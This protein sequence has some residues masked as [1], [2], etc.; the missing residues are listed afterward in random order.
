MDVKGFDKEKIIRYWIDSA[1]EDYGTMLTL[2]ENNKNSWALFVGHLV[3]EKLLKGLYVKVNED[4]PPL[5]HNLLRLAELC[6]L[7]LNQEE[8]LFYATVTTFNINA[9]YDDYKTNFRKKCT[10]EYTKQWVNEIKD[11]KE[12]IQK[13]IT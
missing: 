3:I 1:E 12:W 8:K 4:Y 7:E 9:R 13:Q 2:Y 10:P 5:I 6:G 11:K